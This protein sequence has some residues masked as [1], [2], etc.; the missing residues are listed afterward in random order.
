M[1]KKEFSERDICSKS[2][3]PALTAA[4]W[5]LQTQ[6]RDQFAVIPSKPPPG[7]CVCAQNS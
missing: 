1:D 2:I 3:T 4:G 7:L 5:D 6:I